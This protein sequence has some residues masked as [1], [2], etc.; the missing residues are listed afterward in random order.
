MVL[1]GAGHAHLHLL[2]RELP[3]Y[4][5]AGVALSVVDPGCFWYS[6]LATGMLAGHHPPR[7]DRIDPAAMLRGHQGVELIR[8]RATGLDRA[9]QVVHTTAGALRYDALSWNI[10]SQTVRP[11]GIDDPSLRTV[12]PIAGLAALAGEL[13]ER[14]RATISVIGGGPTGCETAV[15]L[16][17]LARA[18]G[19]ELRVR[20][21]VRS[22]R[23]LG[24][25]SRRLQL[26]LRRHLCAC[27]VALVHGEL[28]AVTA[29]D[30]E[31]T[32][33]R[34][35]P[36]DLVLLATGLRAPALLGELGLPLRDGGLL[37]DDGLASVD[38]PRI[39]AAGDCA[40]L[41]GHD[42][43]LLGVFGVRQAPILAH[44]LLASLRGEPLRRYQPQRR[45]LQILHLG[46]H[47]GL[48]LRGGAWWL[49]PLMLHWKDQLDRRFMA[50]HRRA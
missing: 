34:R 5:A 14:G 33:G 36:G 23:L 1:I 2:A 30:L 18:A 25:P 20:L 21:V 49:H 39:F 24:H 11:A 40:A 27:G 50:R 6:G 9:R 26:R 15:C 3:R 43:P 22:P 16:S 7:A 13:R 17:E 38:D 48:A 42:L 4:R 46:H 44:N 41:R 45:W 10:G 35:L 12:K 32:D 19:L 8:A 31:L 28:A 47:H 29:G 37:I